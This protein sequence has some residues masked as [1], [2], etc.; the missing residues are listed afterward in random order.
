MGY[1]LYRE[2][3]PTETV[4]TIPAEHTGGLT[5]NVVTALVEDDYFRIGAF[6]MPDVREELI[7]V[8]FMHDAIIRVWPEEPD[9]VRELIEGV[10]PYL[11]EHPGVPFYKLSSN[12]GWWV[13][14]E[15]IEAGLKNAD[16]RNVAWRSELSERVLEFVVWMEGSA[17]GFRVH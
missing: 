7:N 17:N 9:Q 12:D 16:E 3:S 4:G 15:E 1:D 6:G 8:G 10:F 2:G 14:R 11:D 13:R 5:I